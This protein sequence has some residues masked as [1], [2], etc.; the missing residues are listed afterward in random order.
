MLSA[1]PGGVAA[2]HVTAIHLVLPTPQPVQ[3][4][5]YEPCGLVKLRRPKPVKSEYVYGAGTVCFGS[6]G[7]NTWLSSRSTWSAIVG[8]VT[9]PA[10]STVKCVAVDVP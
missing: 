10:A 7:A 4:Y 5:E 3:M 8:A 2:S 9:L 1:V 6:A